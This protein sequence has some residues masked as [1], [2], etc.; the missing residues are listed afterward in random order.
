MRN[1]I[2]ITATTII[3][4]GCQDPACPFKTQ[5]RCPF[6]GFQ[7]NPLSLLLKSH[8][9]STRF[10]MAKSPPLKTNVVELASIAD[11]KITNV[12]LYNG[13]AE[14]TRVC[15]PQ[16]KEGDNKVIISGLPNVLLQESLRCVSP[17]VPYFNL[18]ICNAESR[19]MV[20]APFMRFPSRI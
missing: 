19:A 18:T 17:N 20:L 13:L 12:S 1:A 11:S 8:P 16:L 7:L 9:F 6:L 14:I 4:P 2:L 5:K 10:S 15:T 3:P